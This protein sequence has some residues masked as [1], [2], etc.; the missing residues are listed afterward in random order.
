MLTIKFSNC[1]KNGHDNSPLNKICLFSNCYSN[2]LLCEK[3]LN[4]ED[5]QSHKESTMSLNTYIKQMENCKEQNKLHIN[6]MENQFRSSFN[7]VR[8]KLA[9]LRDLVVNKLQTLDASILECENYF[10]EKIDFETF[11]LEMNLNS[12]IP[13]YFEFLQKYVRFSSN[14]E[15]KFKFD[16][17]KRSEI[18]NF[19]HFIQNITD[20]ISKET[21]NIMQSINGILSFIEHSNEIMGSVINCFEPQFK[22]WDITLSKAN[23]V[24]KKV[25]DL[26][27]SFV[28]INHDLREKE[29]LLWAFRIA[30]LKK[31][32]DLGVGF[33]DMLKDCSKFNSNLNRIAI[34]YSSSGNLISPYPN[35][36]I[37]NGKLPAPSTGDIVVF[38]YIK[39]RRILYIFLNQN[40][41]IKLR[42]EA[43]SNALCPVVV[44][45]GRGDEVQLLYFDDSLKNILN[46]YF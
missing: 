44:L 2:Y 22:S 9:D 38:K 1:K 18:N 37:Q 13:N 6:E 36:Q 34:T 29:D 28:L 19:G 15:G 24:A 16:S 3:C 45:A 8:S 46:N 10:L 43:L 32:I 12:E 11:D 39:S 4:D 7:R 40:R 31:R 20:N 26:E 25:S 17:E 42:I 23:T 14:K 27:N 21:K 41:I 5:H 35:M 30:N 33:R